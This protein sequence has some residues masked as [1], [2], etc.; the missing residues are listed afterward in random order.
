M[1][2]RV[3]TLTATL[4]MVVVGGPMNV[5]WDLSRGNDSE[6]ENTGT[7]CEPGRSSSRLTAQRGYFSTKWPR[8]LDCQ[9]ASLCSLQNGRSLP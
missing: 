6:G 9:H 1:S 4:L 5:E 3:S 8:R 7:A 2:E